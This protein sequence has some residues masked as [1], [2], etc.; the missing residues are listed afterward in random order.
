MKQKSYPERSYR[1]FYIWLL[2][3]A[4][5]VVFC[6]FSKE[7]RAGF[8]AAKVFGMTLLV[9]LDVLGGLMAATGSIYWTGTVTY[10]TARCI[11]MDSCR[12]IALYTL[13]CFL[14]ATGL[15]G[16]YC[17][18]PRS[19]FWRDSITDALSAAGCI[20][21][22]AVLAQYCAEKYC[23]EKNMGDRRGKTYEGYKKGGRKNM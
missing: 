20:C 12:R 22:A 13:L 9:L 18:I 5:A 3:A 1:L 6:S 19:V 11:G 7:V 17:Y 2:A 10:D 15:Y 4:G 8:H 14:I 21:C 23:K 16:G